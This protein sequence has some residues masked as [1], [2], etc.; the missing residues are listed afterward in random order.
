[1]RRR[2]RMIKI[3]QT[4]LFGYASATL[5]MQ[6]CIC[7]V[8][9]NWKIS[10]NK[11]VRPSNIRTEMYAG[12]VT[13]CLPGELCWVRAAL[14]YITLKKQVGETDIW[15]D[16]RTDKRTSDWC[17]TF[18]AI[19]KSCSFCKFP[20]SPVGALPLHP[21]GVLLFY[22]LPG[23]QRNIMTKNTRPIACQLVSILCLHMN[24]PEN[25]SISSECDLHYCIEIQLKYL[26]QPWAVIFLFWTFSSEGRDAWTD[27][28]AGVEWTVA[29]LY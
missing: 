24:V 1:M 21:S 22:R 17:I 16:G 11:Y 6:N 3:S 19:I 14:P 26:T 27:E 2:R 10:V 5:R 13:G 20:M 9:K 12:R 8:W 25:W 29:V 15:T 18:T 28:T 23:V 7:V 4:D